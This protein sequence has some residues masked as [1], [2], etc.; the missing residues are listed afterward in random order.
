M[1]T[2][3][4]NIGERMG[5]SQELSDSKRGPVIGGH[6]GNKSIRDIS[7]LLNIPRSTVSGI[8][9][10]WKQLGTTATQPP[11]GRP[12]HMTGRGQRMLKRTVRRSH[13]LSAESIAKDL[14][15]WC[16]L[17]MSPT[18]VRRELHGMGFHGRAAASKPSIAKCNAKCLML[19]CKAH[20][21]W[22]VEQWRRV[23]WSDQ[24][25]FSVW[26]SHGRVWV[27]WWPGERYLPDCI[28]PSVKFGE[29]GDYGRGLFFRGWA[30]PPSSSEGNS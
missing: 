10:K 5:R 21:H 14:Q 20:R 27:W 13:Q 7:W 25:R 6:L 29:G 11:S 30:W 8:I 4:T 18:T 19:W 24:S 1:Q 15:T 3:S 2:A 26:Q 23:L 22:T 17:Q 16:G 9:T 28:V 12:R